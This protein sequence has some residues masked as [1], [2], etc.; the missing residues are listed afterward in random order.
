MSPPK[1]KP[2]TKAREMI[3]DPVFRSCILP[4]GHKGS[5]RNPKRYPI[6]VEVV[7]GETFELTV[8]RAEKLAD[9]IMCAV[10]AHKENA[11][12]R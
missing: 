8:E 1:R 2:R 6:V 9:E 3:C 11:R 7:A 5:H 10:F 12:D 4:H